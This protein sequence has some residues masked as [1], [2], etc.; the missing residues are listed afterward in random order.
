MI[1]PTP[2]SQ[3]EGPALV[4]ALLEEQQ[5]TTA[6]EKF[7]Q[8]HARDALPLNVKQYRDLIPLTTPQQ[9]EQYAFEVDLDACSGCKSCVAACHKKARRGVVWV[10]CTGERLNNR[11]FST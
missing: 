7:A 10:C 3:P 5:P 4:D 9:G 8:L 6:V 2:I 1:A 11:L